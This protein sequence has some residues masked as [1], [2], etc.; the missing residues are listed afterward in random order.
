MRIEY[1]NP[2]RKKIN[3]NLYLN[4]PC[5]IIKGERNGYLYFRNRRYD[6]KCHVFCPRSEGPID[7]YLVCQKCETWNGTHSDNFF[8]KIHHETCVEAQECNSG[9]VANLKSH[10]CETCFPGLASSWAHLECLNECEDGTKKN[11]QQCAFCLEGE[12]SNLNHTKCVPP[13]ECDK[14]SYYTNVSFNILRWCSKCQNNTWALI[15]HSKCVTSPKN[16][17]PGAYADNPTSQCV[18]CGSLYSSFLKT[19]CVESKYCDFGTRASSLG[20]I[21]EC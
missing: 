2:K 8:S 18:S 12:Y 17:D 13:Q 10:Q 9:T 4:L 3:L 5:K 14:E 1:A 20:M 16:C 11:L 6:E 15:N 21:N 7:E 19:S